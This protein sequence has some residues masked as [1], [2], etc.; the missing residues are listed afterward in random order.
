M[1]YFHF[2]E[3][4]CRCGKCA[5]DGRGMD[6]ILTSKLDAIRARLGKPMIVTSGCRCFEWN[7]EVGGSAR[8]FHLPYNGFRAADIKC[9]D[10][11]TRWKMIKLGI[12]FGLTMGVNKSFI[13][14]DTRQ[15]AEPLIFTYD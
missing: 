5:A 3:F 8:S 7:Q 15:I 4:R 11:A 1:R 13:H 10:S 6:R 14:F 2:S 12:E 9:N